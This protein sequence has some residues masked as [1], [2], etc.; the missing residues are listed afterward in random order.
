MVAAKP[1]RAVRHSPTYFE[2]PSTEMRSLPI[3][4]HLWR[5]LSDFLRMRGDD[6]GA[7]AG[8]TAAFCARFG[9]PN[10]R[11]DFA[12]LETLAMFKLPAYDPVGIAIMGF[13][14]LLVVGLAFIF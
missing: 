8:Q 13:G 6:R 10:G 5:R 12:D 7:P 3:G 1:P 14:V 2:P 4:R 9:E 11:C